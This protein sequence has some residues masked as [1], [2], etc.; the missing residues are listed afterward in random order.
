MMGLTTMF[1]NTTEPGIPAAGRS[2]GLR[3][4]VVFNNVVQKPG[5]LAGWGFSCLVEGPEK[6]ILFDT[7]A[8]GAVLLENLKRLQ[9]EA[10]KIDAVFISHGHSDHTGGLGPLLA[11]RPGVQVYL[12]ASLPA[13]FIQA[14]VERGAEVIRVKRGGRLLDRVYSTGE[15]GDSPVE[16]AM[17]VE[18]D[19]G[20][21]VITG[22]A[23]PGIDR[24]AETAMRLTGKKIYL[25]LGG[26]HLAFLSPPE[27]LRI[28]DRLKALGVE[29][30]APSHC[31]GEEATAL[32]RRGWGR[33]FVEGGL[34]A[35]IS[36]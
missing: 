13:P 31:T 25:L 33:N 30:V 36:E 17:I 20:L 14:A 34:G 26:F 32:F 7:G 4:T 9:R 23:H 18:T 22:C 2:P 3:L 6:T 15:L 28:I 10:H 16:Q 11:R 12:P 1:N 19:K 27:I 8:D 29:K 24:I 21:I 35:V 5:L